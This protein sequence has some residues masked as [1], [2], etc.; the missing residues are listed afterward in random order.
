MVSVAERLVELLRELGV[1]YVFG[2]PS[3]PWIPYMEAM[4]TGGVEFVLVSNEASAGFMA[5][6][7]ARLTGVPGACYGT[8]G[9]GAT[10]LSTGVG[11]A[12]LDRSP[13]L[14]FTTE[15]PEAMLGRKLQMAIDHQALYRPLTKWTTRLKPDRVDETLYQAVQ[16][17]TSEVP[18]PVHIGLPADIGEQAAAAGEF[19]PPAPSPV[20]PPDPKLLDQAITLFRQARRPLLAVGL[21]AMRAK[22]WDLV[23]QI[24]ERHRVPV[25]LTPMAKGII[26]E[27]HPC[28]AGVLF[29]ALS[30]RVA[31][32]HGE[33][34]LVIGIGYDPIEFNYEDWMPE[35]PL[36]HIDTTPADIDRS[37]Y[38]LAC[39]L[40][41]DLRISL[42]HF[43]S[44]EPTAKDWDLAALAGRRKRM[45]EALQP[46][47]GTFGPRA[48]L[49][50]LREILPADGVMTC[51]VGAH[52]HLIGQQWPTPAPGLQLMTNGWSSMGF[53]IPAAIAAKLCLP[54]R[55]VA[56]VTGDGGFLMMVGE[57]ATALRLGVHVV[58]VLLADHSLELIRI[59][60]ERKGFARYGTPL[61]DERYASAETFFGVPVLLARDTESY[62]AALEEAFA[63]EGPVIVEAF[64]DGAEYDGLVLRRHK[65]R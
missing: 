18:G 57:M 55:P 25:V 16:I 5:D 64:I 24:A 59:K 32:T 6:V 63:M 61:H 7:C 44:L 13:L 10:N 46:S 37:S 50:I 56:C 34:D 28:Y 20:S 42:E 23:R 1:R 17:A 65:A 33:A 49:S 48:A 21:T 36:V 15:P 3:G 19:T 43:A 14:A 26:P 2:I 4:R 40:V 58:F 41:G 54:E 27:D 53:G 12:L 51:D 62:R 30:D 35:V 9:P 11:G 38:T 45:F 31:E 39:D 8:F 52:T 22:A 29:H 47:A 60:Q